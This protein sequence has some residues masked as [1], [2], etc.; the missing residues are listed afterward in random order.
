MIPKRERNI[1][2]FGEQVNP[3]IDRVVID[4]A[5]VQDVGVLVEEIRDLL[6]FEQVSHSVFEGLGILQRGGGRLGDLAGV[7]TGVG[8]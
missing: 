6:M 1:A 4:H 8:R 7:E 5:H 2:V 3:F